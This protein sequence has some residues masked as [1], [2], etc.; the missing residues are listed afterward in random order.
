MTSHEHNIMHILIILKLAQSIC[1]K[2][3]INNQNSFKYFKKQNQMNKMW[4]KKE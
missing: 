4:V 2:Q 3:Q 1:G